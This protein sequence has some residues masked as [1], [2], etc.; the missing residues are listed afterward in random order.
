MSCF[1]TVVAKKLTFKLFYRVR[2]KK[3]ESI[4]SLELCISFNCCTG[5]NSLKYAVFL[6]FTK[7]KFWGGIFTYRNDRLFPTPS[8]TSTSELIPDPFI[9]PKPE[10]GIPSGRSLR[11]IGLRTVKR[12]IKHPCV[13]VAVAY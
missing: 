8:Y 3:L 9:H 12:L 1:Y 6:T 7:P 4:P 11:R 13:G 2:M 10:N 5:C